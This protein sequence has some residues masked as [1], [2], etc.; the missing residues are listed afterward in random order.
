MLRL[1]QFVILILGLALV[2]L[3]SAIVTMRFAIHGAEV[4]I[5]SFPALPLRK[6]RPKPPNSAS[7]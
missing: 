5:P 1:F 6:P 4:K 3:T 7:R 2:A